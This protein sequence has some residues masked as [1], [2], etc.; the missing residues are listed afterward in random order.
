M[1]KGYCGFYIAGGM[2][3]PRLGTP[4][5]ASSSPT[6]LGATASGWRAGCAHTGSRPTSSTRRVF[7]SH[8]ST[9]GRRRVAPVPKSSKERFLGGWGAERNNAAMLPSPRSGMEKR[10]APAAS[11]GGLSGGGAPPASD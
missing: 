1:R 2:K 6:K 3:Q 10:G 4:S 8:V 5:S 9:G 7:L 11:G